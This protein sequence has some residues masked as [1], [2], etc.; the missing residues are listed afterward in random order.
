M[1]RRDFITF[2]GA[3]SAA[4][5]R[6]AWTQQPRGIPVVGVLMAGLE[7]AAAMRS[8]S[9]HFVRVWRDS[10]GRGRQRPHIPL[11]GR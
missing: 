7:T 11:V 2:I 1:R 4:W 6:T 8:G 3:A 10:A 5:P 9:R